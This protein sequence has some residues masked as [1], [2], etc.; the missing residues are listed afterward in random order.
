MN[1]RKANLKT[2]IVAA[3][4]ALATLTMGASYGFSGTQ[5]TAPQGQTALEVGL[6][7]QVHRE[8]AMLPYYGVFDNL[9]YQI[10][11]TEVTLKGSVVNAVTKSDAEGS[12]KHIEGVTRVVNDIT[13]LPLSRFDDRIRRAEYRSIFSAGTLGYYS[14]G[15]NPSIHII[16]DNGH[17]TLEGV[18][19]REA[20]RDLAGIRANS[21]PGVFS[22]T[23]NLRVE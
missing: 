1:T 12:V 9:E 23:N 5:S 11:G 4:L 20:D 8:L 7:K 21:V 19:T 22:M 10:T 17:V 2:W 13:V 16:V 18:V 6:N 14:M 15:V 3:G